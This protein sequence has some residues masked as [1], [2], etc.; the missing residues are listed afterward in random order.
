MKVETIVGGSIQTNCYII[1]SGNSCSLFDFVPEAEDFIKNRKLKVENVFLTHIHFDHFENLFDFQ[2]RYDFK[3]YMSQ[4]AYENINDKSKN[5]L[6]SIPKEFY[7]DVL[8][9][10][11]DNAEILYDNAVV[12]WKGKRIVALESP[13]HSEDSLVYILPDEK[14]VFSGDTIFYGSIGR[15][16]LSGS[17]YDDIFK[18]I[19][20]LFSKISDEFILYP[21]H[22][23][24][25][26][27]EFEK[28]HNYFLKSG[29]F[30]IEL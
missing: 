7:R 23:P 16:D 15:T 8:D 22:G 28:K 4:I 27:V 30:N 21:G 11:L 10:K 1:I 20:K 12:E 13:G 9:V 3:L 25:T 5:L 14:I 2:K 19:K 24:F 29:P 17:S 18:S 6:C 26:N